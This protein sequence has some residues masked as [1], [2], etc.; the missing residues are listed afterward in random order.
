MF[1]LNIF[2]LVLGIGLLYIGRTYKAMLVFIFGLC[3]EEICSFIYRFRTPHMYYNEITK[4]YSLRFILNSKEFI[5]IIP[6]Q[7]IK[8]NNKIFAISNFRNKTDMVLK[9]LGPCG[10]FFGTKLTPK[11]L[12]LDS[13]KI[14]VN[15]IQYLFN[16][17]SV[18]KFTE[19]MIHESSHETDSD[20]EL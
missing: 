18:I 6:E 13:L 5:M 4:T 17:N 16:E 9:I 10:N 7:E 8:E 19:D 12:G 20:M 1:L 2:L 3:C 11:D 14:W 15:K